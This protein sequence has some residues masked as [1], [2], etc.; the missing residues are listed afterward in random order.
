MS[1]KHC[2]GGIRLVFGSEYEFGSS[3]TDPL[4]VFFSYSSFTHIDILHNPK[5][6]SLILVQ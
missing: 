2:E 5:T 1:S 3:M 6:K 4:Y